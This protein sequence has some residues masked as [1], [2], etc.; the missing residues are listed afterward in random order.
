MKIA[1]CTSTPTCTKLHLHPGKVKSEPGFPCCYLDLEIRNLNLD[2]TEILLMELVLLDRA[3]K[4]LF[5]EYLPSL[6]NY[7]TAKVGRNSGA[8]GRLVS[9]LLLISSLSKVTEEDITKAYFHGN[10]FLVHAYLHR[11]IQ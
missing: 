10:S 9:L 8:P 2:P 3:E 7:V 6:V 4:I 1:T 5:P 11:Y